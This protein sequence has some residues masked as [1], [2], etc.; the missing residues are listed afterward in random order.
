VR[1]G[2][3]LEY[4]AGIGSDAVRERPPSYG[5]GRLSS[6]GARPNPAPARL[7]ARRALIAIRHLTVARRTIQILEAEHY[8]FLFRTRAHREYGFASFEDFAR[9]TLQTS[10]RNARRHVA[11]HRLV[12]TFPAIADALREG[13]VDASHAL[14]LQPLV[15]T[16][17]LKPWIDLAAS[18]SVAELQAAV[19]AHLTQTGSPLAAED[20]DEPGRR[21]T[22]AAPRSA[23][24]VWDHGLE[25]ARR[26]LGREA[27]AHVCLEAILS[28][29]S[30]HFTQADTAFLPPR[31][32][33]R[34]NLPDSSRPR[35]SPKS[36]LTPEK[37]P[38]PARQ[39]ESKAISGILRDSHGFPEEMD[40]VPERPAALEALRSSIDAAWR[41]LS[42]LIPHQ[43]APA[44]PRRSIA[45]LRAL[46]AQERSLRLVL[47]RMIRDLE[48]ARLLGLLGFRSVRQL[49]AEELKLS[50][51]TAQRLLH[52]AWVFETNPP[53]R[54][55]F[56]NGGIGLGQAY[57]IDRTAT[58]GTTRDFISRASSVT[59]LQFEREIQFRERLEAN[60]PDLAKRFPGPFP[61]PGLEAA[62]REQLVDLGWTDAAIQG[63]LC[64]PRESDPG[65]EDPASHSLLLQRLDRL[66]EILVLSLE[67]DEGNQTSSTEDRAPTLAA[68]HQTTISFW[69]PQ[70]II[71]HWERCLGAIRRRHGPLPIWALATL[72]LEAVM[73]E[74]CKVDPH[75]RPWY[76]IQ[77]RDEWR[78]QAPGCSARRHLQTHHIIFKSHGG[79]DDPA[80]LITIC[81]GHHRLVH[82]DTVTVSGQAPSNLL[83]KLGASGYWIGNKRL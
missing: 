39:E 41:L 30:S 62:L 56:E 11:L 67:E 80:N 22:F 40:E 74:W 1:P 72:L 58:R 17:E 81:Y 63:T 73:T 4:P 29:A 2:S 9:E 37:D 38:P 13:R 26:V 6:I 12:S 43:H 42:E 55:A 16:Q 64:E 27:P 23:A 61:L 5:S 25:L 33:Q 10:A 69:A 82:E 45:W 47:V 77:E 71:D 44:H 49:M 57:L 8:E 7:L 48:S 28:E 14:A 32:Q 78:C 21:V 31:T 35:P 19:A 15:G 50:G 54:R 52:E 83:W 59:H 79:S 20:P 24:L 53:L 3:G 18:R 60:L 76:P 65:A 36:V 46:R 68:R 51:R 66:L 34:E 70:T 75:A